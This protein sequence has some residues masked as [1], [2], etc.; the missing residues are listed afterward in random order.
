MK[1]YT[2]GT[3]KH[4]VSYEFDVVRNEV[5][6]FV[7]IEGVEF[8]KLYKNVEIEFI[9]ELTITDLMEQE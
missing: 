4:G 6:C 5:R 9:K 2:S 1:K 3:N 7:I 8:E